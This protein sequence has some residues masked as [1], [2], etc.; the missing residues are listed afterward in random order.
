MST[1]IEICQLTPSQQ[2]HRPV[3]EWK[4]GEKSALVAKISGLAE[5]L[6][7]RQAEL[8]NLSRELNTLKNRVNEA[9]GNI[10]E[11]RESNNRLR[12]DVDRKNNTLNAMRFVV[13][14]VFS[15]QFIY[16]MKMQNFMSKIQ[17][18]GTLCKT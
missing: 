9:N 13:F 17:N 16:A 10:A 6:N 18:Q 1:S 15:G 14:V 2:T 8:Q 5:A 7:N 12:E 11:L 4:E 3:V